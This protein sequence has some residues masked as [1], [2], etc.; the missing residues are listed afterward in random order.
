MSL[1]RFRKKKV[2]QPMSIT[3]KEVIDSQ[4]ETKKVS[5]EATKNAVKLNKLLTANGITL[6]IS[7]AT[8][9]RH[10]H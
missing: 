7:R 5:N 1:L 4:I 10:G 3:P 8:G 2:D 6:T 9:G